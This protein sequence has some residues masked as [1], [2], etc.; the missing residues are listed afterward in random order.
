MREVRWNGLWEQGWQVKG[1]EVH[2]LML[3]VLQHFH[4]S[5]SPGLSRRCKMYLIL[6][7]W[8]GQFLNTLE[9]GKKW[10]LLFSVLCCDFQA[11]V[12]PWYQNYFV[13]PSLNLIIAI[14]ILN[15]RL[16]RTCCEVWEKYFGPQRYNNCVLGGRKFTSTL[17]Q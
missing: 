3:T 4:H 16:L 13:H 8:S 1:S 15:Q 12:S 9:K 7:E 11:R 17:S 5:L 2:Y 6:W 10:F 14:I